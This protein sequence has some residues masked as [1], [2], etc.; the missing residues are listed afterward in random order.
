MSGGDDGEGSAIDGDDGGVGDKGDGGGKQMVQTGKRRWRTPPPMTPPSPFLS[1]LS[2]ASK[3]VY[4]G[5]PDSFQELSN[6]ILPRRLSA[7]LGPRSAFCS[8]SSPK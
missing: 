6:T 1:S 8:R 2:R 5:T 4:R 3:E 7:S